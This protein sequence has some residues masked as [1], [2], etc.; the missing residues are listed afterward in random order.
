MFSKEG[1]TL[2]LI[3]LANP[4][5]FSLKIGF[6]LCGIAEEPFCF[7][8]KILLL[9]K[10]QFFV[11]VLFQ[12]ANLSIELAIIPRVEKYCACLSLGIICVDIGSTLSFN[13]FAT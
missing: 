9:L 5:K 2:D 12:L 8:P 13:F 10:L 4:V 11:N 1:I 7:F 3:N 6:F